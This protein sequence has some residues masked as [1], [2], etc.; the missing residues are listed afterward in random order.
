M[1]KKII[2]IIIMVLSLSLINVYAEDYGWIY[3]NESIYYKD[4]I[5]GQLAKGQVVIDGKDYHFDENT[6]QRS[7]NVTSVN[8]KLYFYGITTGVMQ[9]GWIN[10]NGKTYYADKETGVITQGGVK[11]IDGSPY[12]FG[13]TTGAV[14]KGL[15][16]YENELYYG[17]PV[18]GELK[19]GVTT[20]DGKGYFF[21]ITTY[22][23]QRGWINYNN[24]K[25]YA[26]DSGQLKQGVQLVDNNY[27][28]FGMTT[29]RALTGWINYNGKTYYAD[30]SSGT[31]NTSVNASIDGSYYNFD[32][33][34]VLQS[35]WQTIYGKQ[36]YFF[37]NGKKAVGCVKIAGTRYLFDS[38][39]V[40]LKSNVKLWIDASR[41]QG[42]INWDALWNSGE[43]DGV[44]LKIGSLG[45]VDKQF[46]YNINAV[47]RLGIPY[48]VYVFSYAEN[49]SE[50]LYEANNFIRWFNDFKL[51]PSRNVYY[52]IESWYNSYDGHSSSTITT[53]EYDSIITT[54]ISKLN[55]VGI[56]CSVYT[57]KNYAEIKLS[58][59]VRGYVDWIAHYTGD[60]ILVGYDSS[61][62]PTYVY[63]SAPNYLT[64]YSYG[65]NIWQYSDAGSVTG[66]NGYVD[67]NIV[68]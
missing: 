28:F 20:V 32:S 3:D 36:Y 26:D 23:A 37:A 39:G 49:S 13:I 38:N 15:I 42:T 16:S 19:S 12:F 41:W 29:Y 33:Y 10:Y 66:I 46:E 57:Y 56:G 52:D 18:S 22:K 58:S 45:V 62:K 7:S 55:S 51:S 8:G 11:K 65:W 43:I 5:T 53:S 21:G 54:F 61:G 31:L 68:I 48:T 14:Q 44:I 34:G 17:D 40:L 64:N 9:K 50:A 59:N 35:G 6:G 24:L 60:A 47:K 2:L 67:L 25:Y 1:Y 63:S 30:L 4:P 27:Y